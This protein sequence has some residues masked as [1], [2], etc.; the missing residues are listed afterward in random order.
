[1]MFYDARRKVNRAR[2]HVAELKDVISSHIRA[3]PINYE[4]VD[5]TT[6]SDTEAE[7]SISFTWP[8]SPEAAPVIIGDIIHNLRASLD[9]MASALARA[10]SNS[11]KGVHFPFSEGQDGLDDM[12]GRK[13]FRRCG[14]PAIALLRSLRP[15]RGGNDDLRALHDLDLRDKHRALVPE[16][17]SHI[18]A[19]VDWTIGGPS[20]GS[21]FNYLFAFPKDTEFAHREIVAVSEYLVEM[22]ESILEAFAALQAVKD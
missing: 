6:L 16:V 9:L 11:D 1:M 10:N 5:R 20:A 18:Q 13:H 21:E 2:R 17:A 4:V 12:I 3:N 15:Y 8:S 19:S 14:E 7:V 22:C